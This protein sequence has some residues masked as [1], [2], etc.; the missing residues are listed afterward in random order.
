MKPSKVWHAGHEEFLKTI[1]PAFLAV[2]EDEDMDAIHVRT[3][4]IVIKDSSVKETFSLV[5]SGVPPCLLLKHC[6]LTESQLRHEIVIYFAGG[7]LN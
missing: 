4:L 7:I 5:T 3:H 2:D 6:S 1:K